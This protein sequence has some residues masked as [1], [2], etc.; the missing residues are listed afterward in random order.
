GFNTTA[1]ALLMVRVAPG[2]ITVFPAPDMVPPLQLSWLSTVT[3][4]LPLKAPALRFRIP[5]LTI[6]LPLKFAVPPKGGPVSES[7][8]FVQ[9]NAPTRLAVPP[10]TVQRPVRF[11]SPESVAV[12]PLKLRLP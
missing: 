4:L 1:L 12:A 8:L 3:T 6:E 11:T 10:L 9:I 2:A 5:G 7:V